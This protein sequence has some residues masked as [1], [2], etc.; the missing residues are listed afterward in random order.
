MPV[1]DGG[2]SRNQQTFIPIRRAAA[3]LGVP[4][5]WLRREAEAGRV[6]AVRAGTR[7]LVHLDRAQTVLT[8]RAEGAVSKAKYPEGGVQ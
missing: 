6:P 1:H 2:M 8:E 4:V 5:A 7:W 3:L